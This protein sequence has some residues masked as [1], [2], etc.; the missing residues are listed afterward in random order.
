MAGVVLSGLGKVFPNGVE[1]VKGVDLTVEEGEFLAI[2]GPSG[3]GKSTLLRLVAGL[4]TPTAG[5]VWIGGRDVTRLAPRQRDVGMVFQDPALFPYLTVFDNLAFGLC[6]RGVERD[7]VRKRVVTVAELLGLSAMLDRRP[8][9]LSGGQRQRVALGR[10]VVRRPALFLFDEPLS[11]LDA[12]L[13]AA[14]RGDL[15]DLHRTLGATILHVTHDQAE[16]LAV[17]DRVAVMG[18]GHLVQAGRPREVFERPNSRFVAQ[19]VGSPPM[20][21]LPC[22][23]RERDGG[24]FAC[25]D[26]FDGGP[27]FHWPAGDRRRIELGLRPDHLSILRPGDPLPPGLTSLAEA[28]RVIRVEYLGHESIPTLALGPYRLA[29]RI[30]ATS[31]L[32]AGDLVRLAFRL[33]QASWFDPETGAAFYSGADA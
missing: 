5:A 32:R 24:L 28:A 25:V 15:I 19:F 10:A 17:S 20:N 8:G 9:T 18:H 13:R 27:S 16:A 7:E 12:P 11:G 1:A 26:G 33:D 23:I 31:E 6:A 14:I 3:S 29:A 22:T 2:V 21:V 30:P 4:E